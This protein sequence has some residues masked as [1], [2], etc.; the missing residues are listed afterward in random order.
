[1][2]VSKIKILITLIGP[3]FS[4]EKCFIMNIVNISW[5]LPFTF[6]SL[7]TM[8]YCRPHRRCSVVTHRWALTTAFLHWLARLQMALL[9]TGRLAIPRAGLGWW[10]QDG[11]FLFHPCLACL[12]FFYQFVDLHVSFFCG[13]NSSYFCDRGFLNHAN[14]KP[15]WIYT[16]VRGNLGQS[17]LIDKFCDLPIESLAAIMW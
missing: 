17:I 8:E 9:L 1:M 4:Q 3:Y 7:Q 14:L 11:Q 2:L 5:I 6:E 15:N 10:L 12:A 16:Y 13:T